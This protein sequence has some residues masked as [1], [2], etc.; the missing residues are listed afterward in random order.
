MSLCWKKLKKSI[1]FISTYYFENLKNIYKLYLQYTIKYFLKKL[2]NTYK[3][4]L[5]YYLEISRSETKE[6]QDIVFNIG[7]YDFDF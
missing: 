5:D 4:Y 6:K 3:T 2:L 7:T 1:F